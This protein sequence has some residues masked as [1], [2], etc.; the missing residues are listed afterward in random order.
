V[1]AALERP[2]LVRHLV[3]SVTSGGV[4]MA[5]LG[6]EDWRAEHRRRNPEAPS[7]FV[8]EREDL[9][10]RLPEI[11]IP[12]LLLW[13]DADPISPVAVGRR[14]AE[15]LPRAEL[16]VIDGGTHDLVCDRAGDVA[17]HIEK[18]LSR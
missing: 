1:R 6:A 8:D 7:W 4:D 13:G 12:V 16:V 3:L 10:H 2:G 14:L 5:A 9:S 15:L 11:A 18:H 17:P